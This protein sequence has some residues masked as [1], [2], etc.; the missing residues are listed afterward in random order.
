MSIIVGLL[1]LAGVGFAIYKSIP[2]IDPKLTDPIQGLI[3]WD[4]VGIDPADLDSRKE[5]L[6][7]LFVK[8]KNDYERV[9]KK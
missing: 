9:Y 7:K 1:L 6:D 4:E 8:V 3:D 2:P 5:Y